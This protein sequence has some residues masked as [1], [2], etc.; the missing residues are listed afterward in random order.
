[1]ATGLTRRGVL[2]RE[3]L[4]RVSTDMGDLHVDGD[5]IREHA[6]GSYRCQHVAASEGLRR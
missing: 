5:N 1:M 3:S 4:E 2:R 6:S